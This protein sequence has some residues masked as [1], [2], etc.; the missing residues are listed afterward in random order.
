MND[1]HTNPLLSLS[2]EIP[3][4]AITGEHVEPAVHAL[5]DEARARLDALVASDGPR[6]YASTLDALERVTERLDLAMNVISHLEGAATT[7]ALRAAF[8]AVQPPVSELFSA[9]TLSPGVW[10]AL[11]DFAETDE[12]RALTGTR[13]RFLEKTIADLRRNGAEL[14]EAGKA[15]L[16]AIDVE[17]AT[18]TLRY[19]QNVLDAT[20]AFEVVLPD[21]SRLAGLPENAIEAARESARAKGLSGYRLTL[22]APSYLA[23]LTYCDDAGLREALYRAYNTRASSGAHDNAPIVRRVLELRREKAALL[24]FQSFAD[25]ALEDRMAKSGEAARRFIATL[26]ERAEARMRDEHEELEAFRRSIEG[27][28][29]P[30]LAPWDVGY[31]AE[32]LRKARFDFDDEMLRPYLPLDRAL[33]GAFAVAER[34][35]GVTIEPWEGASTWHPSVLAY[36]VREADG[37]IRSQFYVDVFPRESKRDGAWMHGLVTGVPGDPNDGRH[38]EVL[39][40]NFTPPVGG[41]P[42]LLSHR[43]VETLFHEFGHLMHHAASRVEVRS[44]AGTSVAWDFVELPSQIMENWCW[45]R[46]ALD[47]FARHYQSGEPIPADVLERMRRARTFRA[48]TATMRQLGFAE[49]DLALHMEGPGELDPI[50][51]ARAVLE[52]HSPVRLPDDHAFAASFSHL[53]ASPVGYAAGYYSYKWAEVLEA[54]AFSRFQREGVF[55]RRVG[56]EFRGTILARGDS[57][58]PSALFRAFM[59]RDPTIDALLA[60][61]GLLPPTEDAAR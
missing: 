24:G 35:Y 5:L 1:A 8:A 16:A 56:L 55:D 60:R 34:L 45:E 48:A 52:R 20:N 30:S 53:F 4:A 37:S 21:A 51:F 17:L 32:K 61:D 7:P 28:G 38:L 9:I 49:L 36:R 15:R 3:F 44:L 39:A 18:Q 40:G 2:Y 19:G 23:V 22:Q 6:T 29:A 58:D 25:L 47:L 43:E 14:G 26:R 27:K 59:G 12:A 31:Y 41:R 33:E 11:K 10:A 57:E 54:D 50:R 46:E 13:R 42:A